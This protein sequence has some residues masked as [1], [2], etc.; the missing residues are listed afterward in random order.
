MNI[1]N[2]ILSK[3]EILLNSLI[4]YYY[5]NDEIY[6]ILDIITGQ[7][8]ISLRIIDW[9]ITNYCNKYNVILSNNEHNYYNVYNEYKSQLKAYNKRFFDPFCRINEKNNIKK[10]IFKYNENNYIKTT[11]GQINFFK[12]A[13]NNNII[14]YILDNHDKIY[15]DMNLNKKVNKI[16]TTKIKNKKINCN[17]LD[18]NSNNEYDSNVTYKTI[19]SKNYMKKN[20]GVYT[21]NLS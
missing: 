21:I 17:M 6:P 5:N 16:K 2:K 3:E 15:H 19:K 18:I 11:I 13:T 14:N 12:W 8:N 4:N 9:F 1:M 20:I 10:I 7:S